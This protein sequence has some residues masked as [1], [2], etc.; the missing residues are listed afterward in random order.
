MSEWILVITILSN[1]NGYSG[2]S[3]VQGFTSEEK[4][5]AA[6]EKIG[7]STLR[8]AKGNP[9]KDKHQTGYLHCI[10]IEK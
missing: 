1:A 7:L 8:D 6:S 4:C 10:K 2:I 3:T 9:D 5:M